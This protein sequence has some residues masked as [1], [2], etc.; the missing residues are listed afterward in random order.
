MKN[1]AIRT[2]LLSSCRYKISALALDRKGKV[3]A[4]ACNKL[5]FAKFHGGLHA[6]IAVLHKVN[7]SKVK[8]IIITRV[9]KKG[10]ILPID[11]CP[12]CKKVLTKLGIKIKTIK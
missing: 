9:N 3:I 7:V 6:E 11:P 2:A 12:T 1:I 4:W 10:E 8:T 5:R